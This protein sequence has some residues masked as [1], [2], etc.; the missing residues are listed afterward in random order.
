[1]ATVCAYISK[2]EHVNN[3]L[4]EVFITYKWHV[5]QHFDNIGINI[6]YNE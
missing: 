6:P 2:V 1:M 4:V 3:S 5:N